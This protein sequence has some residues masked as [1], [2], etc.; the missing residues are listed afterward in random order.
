MYEAINNDWTSESDKKLKPFYHF[1]DELS[2]KLSADEKTF[3][4][5]KGNVL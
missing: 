3:V 5:M 4:L 1:R 2:V